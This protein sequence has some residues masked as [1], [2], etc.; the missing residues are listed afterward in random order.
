M[1]HLTN[2]LLTSASNWINKKFVDEK[3]SQK[4][5]FNYSS[6]VQYIRESIDK[7][8]AKIEYEKTLQKKQKKIKKRN[9]YI[10]VSVSVIFLVIAAIDYY[11]KH[12]SLLILQSQQRQIANLEDQKRDL[13]QRELIAQKKQK[14]DSLA[15]ENQR[16]EIEKRRLLL[17][18][19][20]NTILEQEKQV[21]S[22]RQRADSAMLENERFLRKLEKKVK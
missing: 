12:N 2:P 21:I 6:T 19:K 4:Y 20:E 22:Y 10:I 16:G 11:N 1:P 14:E 18:S 13:R 8:N 15:I 3:W 17:E 7:H 5:S 9:I